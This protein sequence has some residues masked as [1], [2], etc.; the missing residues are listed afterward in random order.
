MA[1]PNPAAKAACYDDSIDTFGAATTQ[2]SRSANLIFIEVLKVKH[3]Q[4]A[5]RKAVVYVELLNAV[6][7][8]ALLCGSNW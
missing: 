4:K 3:L 6:T 5:D 7:V 2:R 1:L 8:P